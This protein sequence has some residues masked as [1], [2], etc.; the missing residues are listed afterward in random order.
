MPRQN[1]NVDGKIGGRKCKVRK[2]GCSS[3]SSSS[4]VQN[5]RLKR[6]FLV[7]KR[8]GSS[9]T[10]VP[11]WKMM[12][13]KSPSL[14]NDKAFFKYLA[15]K[16]GERPK[17][18]SVSA[19]K[20][21]ATLWEIDGCWPSPR[22]KRE[23][24]EKDKV[25]DESGGVFVRKERILESSKLGSMV[26]A[27]SD[28]FHSPV[29]ERMDPPKVGS[30]RRRASAGSQKLLQANC[31]LGGA[32]SIHN[33]M[34]EVD[35]TQNPA[36]SPCRHVIGT[37]NHLKDVYNGLVTSKE[38]LKVMSR[39]CRLE[40]QNSTSLSLFSA[41]KFEL[42]R[43]CI[44]VCKLIQEQKA[45]RSEIDVLLK[46]F[47]EEKMVWKLKEQ[48]RIRSAITSIAGELE[49][50]KKLRRQ[51][52]RLNKKLGRELAETK[53]SLSKQTK[54]LESEKRARQ[55]LEQVCD[56]LA[57][58][59]G[60]DRAEVEEL[61]KQS[62]KVREEMEKEL[63]MLQLADVLREERVQMKLLE[64]NPRQAKS[65]QTALQAMTKLRSLRNILR[66][67]LPGSCQYQDKEKEDIV[68]AANKEEEGEEEED[69][70]DSA[71][72]DLHS[73][74]LTVDDISKSF[75][76][77]DAIKN[78]T[79]RSSVDKSKGRKPFQEKTTKPTISDGIGWEF[80]NNKQENLDVFDRRG[81]F[82]FASQ[83]WKKEVED[84]LERYNMIKDL[85]DH[86]VSGSRMVSSQDLAATPSQNVDQPPILSSK[87]PNGLVCQ[88]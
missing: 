86:I 27:L 87:D 53:A 2:R 60:E 34:V 54:D 17:E 64:A 16:G 52:E 37:K 44:H 15:A 57:R 25:S 47:E 82:E 65:N 40:D 12:G 28:L 76:W 74:E 45:N 30:H 79:K 63:E 1:L 56:E 70:D 58:G 48:D 80:T 72:S 67:T 61:K 6:A 88:G 43:A 24:L 31:D 75:Q 4:L 21:A 38:L 9:T 55:I 84:E 49:T 35:Q 23:S 83:P 33:C 50:E 11:M 7:R 81:L 71:D 41:L 10:P 51:T 68:T 20:L 3:S 42:D 46:Q 39:I 8:V 19:R 66:E 77:S 36:R 69:D 29:S 32:K 5:Y 59:I 62:A 13:S 14:E 22:V 78:E 73:I 26:L 18:L 85:R